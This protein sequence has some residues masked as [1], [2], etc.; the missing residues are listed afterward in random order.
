[1]EIYSKKCE[2]FWASISVETEA[3]GRYAWSLELSAH[4]AKVAG[5]QVLQ[6]SGFPR[7]EAA[8]TEAM[9]ALQLLDLASDPSTS[10]H[11]SVGLTLH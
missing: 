2:G 8:M 4:E 11:S 3:D 5:L 9:E 7:R 10:I 6:G 1:M